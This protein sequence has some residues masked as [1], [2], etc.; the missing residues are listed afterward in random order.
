MEAKRARDEIR[1]GCV[2]RN[3]FALLR[4]TYHEIERKLSPK[5]KKEKNEESVLVPDERTFSDAF[6]RPRVGGKTSE[7]G[8]GGGSLPACNRCVRVVAPFGRRRVARAWLPSPRFAAATDG[9]GCA[10]AVPRLL[11]VVW[12]RAQ[13]ATTRFA[14]ARLTCPGTLPLFRRT[15]NIKECH[16]DRSKDRWHKK[17]A[18]EP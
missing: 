9:G 11:V 10:R 17:S 1:I 14:C 2:F 13:A 18:H 8:P 15:K 12:T 6:H 16:G 7:T 3:C 4:L 5:G